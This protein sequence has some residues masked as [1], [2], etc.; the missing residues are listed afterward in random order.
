[1]SF[2][3]RRTY[4][5]STQDY[6]SDALYDGWK[7]RGENTSDWVVELG[8]DLAAN[9]IGEWFTLDDTVKGELDNT[10]YLLA[11]DVLVDL[12]SYV[13]SIKTRRGRSAELEKFTTGTCNVVFDNRD[14]IFDPLITA[15]PLSGN[16]V[17]R[18]QIK[19]SFDGEPVFTGNVDDWDFD[20]TFSDATATV[21]AVDGLQYFASRNVPTQTMT[22]QLTSARVSYVLDQVGWPDDQRVIDTGSAT[23][24]ADVVGDSENALG[25]LQKVERSQNGLMFVA[26]DGT[27]RFDDNYLGTLHPASFGDDG[28]KFQDI[29]VVYGSE[30]LINRVDVEYLSGSSTA[31]VTVD[32]GPSQTQ[33]GVFERSIG[34]LLAASASAQVLGETLLFRYS[35][36]TYR[37]DAATFNLLGLPSGD[38]SLLMDIELGSRCTLKW[39]P[40]G[41]GA[42]INRTVLV[43]GI[44]HSVK[45]KFH[46]VQ[47]QLTDLNYSGEAEL[48]VG[49]LVSEYKQ[50]GK[51]YRLHQFTQPGTYE[52]DVAA[53]VTVEALIVGAGGGIDT[54]A[55]QPGG[56]GAGGVLAGTLNFTSAATYEVVVGEFTQGE[57]GESSKIGSYIAL[58]GGLGGAGGAN[59]DDGGSGGGGGS[60][61]PSFGSGGASLQGNVGT[62]TGYGNAGASA[63]D[64][65]GTAY[66]G[67]GGGAGGAASNEDGG[68]AFS[69]TITGGSAS[70]AAGGSGGREGYFGA[71]TGYTPNPGDG[72]PGSSSVFWLQPAH[73]AVFVR[74]EI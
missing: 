31:N 55:G 1:M 46:T 74:Y 9:G 37:I 42:P 57:S 63:Y 41:V 44:T 47:L 69:S 3:P 35:Q 15:G 20:Y 58:G 38:K 45:P 24:G 72:Y 13:R 2:D 26:K 36:P 48:L 5:T 10:T 7:Y 70:Y 71:S 43:D 64:K 61:D 29:D 65:S 34:T 53:P 56:G 8:V 33:Y 14:R 6:T 67:G 66:S 30:E 21:K 40:L 49:G 11:G 27:F 52:L 17:P 28:I 51:T 54:S 59:G 39:R 50:G 60:S 23:V 22:E 18:K 19:V 12:T 4:E 62:L 16:I 25:Y 73:G 68:A 32:D